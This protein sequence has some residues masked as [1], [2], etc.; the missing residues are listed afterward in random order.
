VIAGNAVLYG[1]TGGRAFIAGRV[2][3]RFA[4]RNSGGLAVV[5]GTGDHACE[6]MTAGAAVIL[7]GTGRNLGAGMSGGVAYV[8]DEEGLLY[9]RHNPELVAVEEGLDDREQGWL[10]QVIARHL[11]LTGSARA[12][13][14]L[15]AWAEWLPRFRR[16]AP[17]AGATRV[18][19]AFKLEWEPALPR[20]ATR[21]RRIAAR[22]AYARA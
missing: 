16:V 10:G 22:G 6:Y 14:I 13:E 20:V 8:L 5:E 19:P 21:S 4:V 9:R 3:E 17:R 1:A 15:D 2:G 11:E 7:G 18:L 12:R